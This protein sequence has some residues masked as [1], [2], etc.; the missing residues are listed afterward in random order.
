MPTKRLL[1][2]AATLRRMRNND[3]RLKDIAKEY[4]VTEA[5][6]WKALDRANLVQGRTTYSEILPWKILPEHRATNIMVMF[7]RILRQ[8][9]GE[10]LPE[11]EQRYLDAWL[12]TLS[13][14]NVVV[15]YHPEAPPNDASRK[16][17]FYYVE[18]QPTDKWIIRE[19]DD[20]A[21]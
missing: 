16:G 15:N 9:K 7:R 14:S 3:W 4:G 18:R 5:A 20:Q 6:V 21:A 10:V 1:P 12:K 13:D 2:D 11:N 19:P 17:G 8:R